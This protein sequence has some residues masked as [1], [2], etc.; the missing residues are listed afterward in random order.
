MGALRR[1]TIKGLQTSRDLAKVIAP[2][3][4]GV[5]I[6]RHTPVLD[7]ITDWFAPFMGLF[8][9][10]GEAALVL[11]LG[12]FV[13]IYASLGA[14][15]SLDFTAK[16]ISTMALMISFSHNVLIET[17]VTKRLGVSFW[18]VLLLRVA[19]GVVAG[20]VFSRVVGG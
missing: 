5:T 9:L 12:N 7:W 14:I 13:N 16:E 4:I 3:Y 15:A 19:L 20:F 11:V 2:A 6:L 17:A 18:G 8:G 1:G 10:R